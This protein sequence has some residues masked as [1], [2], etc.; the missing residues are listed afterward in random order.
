M[1]LLNTQTG[2]VNG[3]KNLVIL[4]PIY[5]FFLLFAFLPLMT[6][7]NQSKIA[8]TDGINKH[9][10]MLMTFRYWPYPNSL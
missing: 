1:K 3:F 7:A 4:K 2:K 8:V 10:R 9:A 5:Y 6:G